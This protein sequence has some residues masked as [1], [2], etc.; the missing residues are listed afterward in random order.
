M[1]FGF[2]KADRSAL[3]PIFRDAESLTSIVLLFCHCHSKAS[4]LLAAFDQVGLNS[5]VISAPLLIDS[6]PPDGE[7]AFVNV[8]SFF[9][10]RRGVK[11]SRFEVRS[12]VV[13]HWKYMT[14]NFSQNPVGRV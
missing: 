11:C 2:C 13:H 7:N 14:S 10:S 9:Q 5:T 6:S 12:L 8:G 4:G 1:K 3:S